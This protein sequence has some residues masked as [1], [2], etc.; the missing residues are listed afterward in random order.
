MATETGEIIPIQIGNCGSLI[1][2]SWLSKIINEHRLN[3]DGIYCKHF[4][5]KTEEMETRLTKI[6][7]YFD[8]IK[9]GTMTK[10]FIKNQFT[11]YVP[12]EILELC[13]NHTSL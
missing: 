13:K 10:G 6:N 8:E 11:S 5:E 2:Q 3:L 12:A 9:A 4:N 1:G 7:S